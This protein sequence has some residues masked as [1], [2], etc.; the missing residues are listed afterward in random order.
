[1][2]GVEPMHALSHANAG[3]MAIVFHSDEHSPGGH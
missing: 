1:M 3:Y 2:G